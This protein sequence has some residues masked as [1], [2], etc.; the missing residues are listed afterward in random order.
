[1]YLSVLVIAFQSPMQFKGPC[2]RTH[3]DSVIDAL[4][5]RPCVE[6]LLNP[7]WIETMVRKA[8]SCPGCRDRAPRKIQEYTKE[9]AV[10][11]DEIISQIGLEIK[12]Y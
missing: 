2:E 10:P 8:G 5:I 9:L 7:E 12:S 4:R 3:Q 1:M 11:L 6:T